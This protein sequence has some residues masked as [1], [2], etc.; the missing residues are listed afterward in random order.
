[1]TADYST[2]VNSLIQGSAVRWT[3]Y[4]DFSTFKTYVRPLGSPTVVTYSFDDTKPN[5]VSVP[6]PGFR[7][8]SD[9]ERA[10]VRTAAGIWDQ[11]SGL[12]LLEV[13][14]GQG[15]IQ[16]GTYNFGG[17]TSSGLDGYAYYPGY[18]I[19]GDVWFDN[20]GKISTGLALHEMGHSLGLKH[21]FDPGTTGVTLPTSEDN[22][23]YSVMSYTGGDVSTIGPYDITA[24]QYLYGQNVGVE[25]IF[26]SGYTP[27][28]YLAANPDLLRAFGPNSVA[29]NNHYLTKGMREGRSTTFDALRYV[30]GNL[31][32]AA[33]F[34][35]NQA[36]A[37]QHYI[38]T[39][40]SEGRSTTGFSP[41]AYLA[42][43]SDLQVF[44][45]NTAAAE[46]HYV[47][48]GLAE[49]RTVTFD[50]Y[51]YMAANRDVMVAFLNNADGATLHFLEHGRGEGRQTTGGFDARSYLAANA[52]LAAAFGSDLNAA[53]RHYVQFGV[54]EGRPTFVV[55]TVTSSTTTARAAMPAETLPLQS[56]TDFSSVA[57]TSQND[58]LQA[59]AGSLFLTADNSSFTVSN[60]PEPSA[61]LAG[62]TGFSVFGSR[63]GSS[64]AAL[65]LGSSL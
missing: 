58:P 31:D 10:S 35:T 62:L 30:A 20:R 48:N 9:Q 37:T 55:P 49:G 59:T 40:V 32:L 36:A 44:G 57:A 15:D 22:K 18:G 38:T 39:G 54:R 1:M 23:T 19:G 53:T 7:P 46:L 12:V 45:T 60:P 5:Y 14:A 4:T 42:S 43:Y 65:A 11:A 61:S 41:L 50:P 64:M 2:Q 8:L 27:Q 63:F 16:I 47:Q 25:A 13:A 17:T 51:L 34:G 21:P 29:A 28:A 52:D 24:I 3:N 56:Y 6:T 33:A 26:P